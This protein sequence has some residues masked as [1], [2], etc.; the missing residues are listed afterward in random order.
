MARAPITVQQASGSKPTLQPAAGSLT[1]NQTAP[2]TAGDGVSCPADGKTLLIAHN[3]NAGAQTVTISSVADRNGRTGDITSYSIAAG[4]VATFG[5][6][7]AE[8]WAQ[9]DGQVYA[10]GSHT[11][12]K[13]GAVRVG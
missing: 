11:D 4:R 6:F 9:A 2:G 8:G 12:V 5:P 3:T 10:A 7:R 13:F 1:V